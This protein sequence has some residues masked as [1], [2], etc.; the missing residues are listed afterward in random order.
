MEITYWEIVKI[1]NYT[2]QIITKYLW[3]YTK[4][5][6]VLVSFDVENM[7]K[8]LFFSKLNSKDSSFENWYQ[9]R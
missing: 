1:E 2:S 9:Y 5:L 3:K 8:K 4:K 7:M 6:F